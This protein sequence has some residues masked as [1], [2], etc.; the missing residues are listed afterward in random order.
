MLAAVTAA[1][2]TAAAASIL[3]HLLW[4]KLLVSCEEQSGINSNLIN[5]CFF[6]IVK[7]DIG[8]CGCSVESWLLWLGKNAQGPDVPVV[9]YFGLQFCPPTVRSTAK[10]GAIPRRSTML[11]EL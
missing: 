11:N 7:N 6:L 2:V 9:H 1:V 3:L 8:G 5:F 4:D 10:K